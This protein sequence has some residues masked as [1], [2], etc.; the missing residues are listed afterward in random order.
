MLGT[1]MSG[2]GSDFRGWLSQPF[3]PQGDALTWFL[4]FGLAS[5]SLI[6]WG[7]ILGYIIRTVE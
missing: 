5:I 7:I 4:F 3:N 6:M 1:A 2:Y